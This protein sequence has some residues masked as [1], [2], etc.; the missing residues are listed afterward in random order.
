MRRSALSRAG[1]RTQRQRPGPTA[2]RSTQL[3][4]RAKFGTSSSAVPE[5]S[6]LDAC[7]PSCG[8]F[9][10]A[11]SLLQPLSTLRSTRLSQ[12]PLG[13]RLLRLGSMGSVATATKCTRMPSG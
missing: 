1:A 11:P 13:R 12:P 10:P 7:T 6:G 5:S 8:A 4:G 3:L 9:R 2:L